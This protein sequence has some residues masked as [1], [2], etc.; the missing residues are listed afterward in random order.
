LSITAEDPATAAKKRAQ[1]SEGDDT[2]LIH[3]ALRWIFVREQAASPSTFWIDVTRS[4][5]KA[6]GRKFSTVKRKII[7]LE[8]SWRAKFAARELQPGLQGNN[9]TELARAMR[10]WIAFRDEEERVKREKEED[11]K[12]L[13]V[14][15]ERLHELE[16]ERLGLTDICRYETTVGGEEEETVAQGVD[17]GERTNPIPLEDA[18]NEEPRP[19][20]PADSLY[21]DLEPTES[22]R[23]PANSDPVA[24]IVELLRKRQREEREEADIRREEQVLLNKRLAMMEEQV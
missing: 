23:K 5:E 14:R 21:R 17:T 22:N 4:F 3:I 13:E 7:S 6:I 2:L 19:S 1:L 9:N 15:R 12:A 10:A 18:V 11:E 24:P 20:R 16:S 8:E